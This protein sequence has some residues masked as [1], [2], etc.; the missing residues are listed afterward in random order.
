VQ[1]SRQRST[2]TQKP[3][4]APFSTAA[5]KLIEQIQAEAR[6]K[7]L[8]ELSAKDAIV[9][10]HGFD[11]DTKRV[12]VSGDSLRVTDEK[13]NRVTMHRR[14]VIPDSWRDSDTMLAIWHPARWTGE[15]VHI[16]A[17]GREWVRDIPP[18]ICD[19]FGDLVEVSA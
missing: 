3:T 12:R 2:R 11:A 13:G 17:I 10:L 9:V 16:D 5:A 8:E 18:H 19:D 15:E 7:L 1:T 4:A 14:H 6:T